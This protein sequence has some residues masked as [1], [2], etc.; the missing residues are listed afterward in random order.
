MNRRLALPFAAI[1]AVGAIALA[2][3]VPNQSED[4]EGIAVSSTAN[5][6][7]VATDTAPAGN[8]VFHVTNDGED[9]TEFYLL[10]SDGLRI[11][12]E[13]ENIGPGIT[14]DLVVQVPE[15]DYLTA[16]K[17]GMVGDGIQAS[18]I[19]T[20]SDAQVGGTGDRAEQL[21]DAADQY[22]L[23]VRD[24]IQTL[25]SKTDAFAAAYLA[26]DDELAREMYADARVHWERIEPVAESFGDLDPMMDAR[27]ADLA[28]GEEWTGWHHIEKNLF[29][30]AEGYDLT[31]A[32]RKALADKLVADTADL[33]ERVNAEDFS[34]DAFQVGNGAKELLDEVAA[35][36]IT[37]EE[38]AWSHTDLWDFQANVDGAAVAFGVLQSTVEETDPELAAELE[39]RFD[40]LNTLLAKYGSIDDGFVLYTDLTEEQV[41]ELANAVNALSEPLSKL[42]AAA[43]L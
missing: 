11:I 43:V 3:C 24:Q 21:A 18:F 12:S 5:A 42:T 36:K 15:G 23:Y 4:S 39:S 9:V 37:G 20:A 8:I 32:E 1:S 19:V 25:V 2:A 35:G 13:I 38:E 29:P 26:G 27:E 34:V 33:S 10:A 31:D 16:C 6:C 17:P 40:D 41:Q 28:E 22:L 7:E 30:P 14:R